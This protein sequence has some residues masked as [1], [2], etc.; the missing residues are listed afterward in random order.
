M[1]KQVSVAEAHALLGD[2]H[3]YVDVRSSAEFAAGHPAGAFNVP[4]LESDPATGRIEPNPD[5]VRV[6]QASFA[7]D[8]RLLLGCQVGGRSQ[9]AGQVLE[10]FGFSDVANVRGGFAGSR[11][12]MSGRVDPGWVESGLPVEDGQPA[13]RDYGT[14]LRKADGPA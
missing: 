13:G 11:N 14:L 12:P 8:T 6:M 10:A 9:Q 1:V 2:G 4:L 5:F 7:A 3:V